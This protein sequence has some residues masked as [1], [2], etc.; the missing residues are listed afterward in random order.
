[1]KINKIFYWVCALGWVF[2]PIERT[3]TYSQ[4]GFS[5]QELLALTIALLFAVSF[6]MSH[7]E[8]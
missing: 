3:I 5:G 8:D 1:M 7:V 6:F 4:D 2:G